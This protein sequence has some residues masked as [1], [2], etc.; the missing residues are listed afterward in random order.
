MTPFDFLS[1]S[2]E[3]LSEMAYLPTQYDLSPAQ[4]DKLNN[5]ATA[6][7][8]KPELVLSMQQ[9]IN[10]NESIKA[11]SLARLKR[12]FYFFNHPNENSGDLDL[13]DYKMIMAIKDN[14]AELLK[15]AVTQVSDSLATDVYAKALYLNKE[16]VA[17]QLLTLAE[18]RN[19]QVREYMQSR[20][21]PETQFRISTVPPSPVADSVKNVFKN[22]FILP[23][24]E[25]IPMNNE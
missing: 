11:L 5:L 24:E 2:S 18:R 10:Y 6:I 8:S 3:S 7:L 4:Y 17:D 9:Y 25:P 16:K 22:S 15:Y 20:Q 21:V 19:R 1:G 23:D 14:D 13:Q 12:D